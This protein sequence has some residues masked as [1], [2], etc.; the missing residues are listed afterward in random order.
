MK[1]LLLILIFGLMLSGCPG[2]GGFF[3]DPYPYWSTPY[4]GPYYGGHIRFHGG[5]HG[6]HS[7]HKAPGGHGVHH[8]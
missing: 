4:Y 3:V 7:G 2:P 5:P 8:K 6:G 1:K